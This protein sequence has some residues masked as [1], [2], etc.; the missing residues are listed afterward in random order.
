MVRKVKKLAGIAAAGMILMTGCGS[1]GVSQTCSTNMM[2]VKL[3]LTYGAKSEN[4]K[5]DSAKMQIVI[6]MSMLNLAG[7]DTTDKEAVKDYVMTTFGGDVENEASM[8]VNVGD[9]EVTVTADAN[10]EI[11][12]NSSDTAPTFKEVKEELEQQS[13]GMFTC[14]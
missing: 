2:G 3:S 13:T 9:E 11:F 8:T 1:N 14:D 12:E 6:P 5:V 7:V 4:D 10:K